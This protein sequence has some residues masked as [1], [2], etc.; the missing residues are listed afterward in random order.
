M[1]DCETLD[2]R[3]PA[4]KSEP[5]I[6]RG[7]VPSPLERGLKGVV[8]FLLPPRC[9]SCREA[10]ATQG[11]LCAECFSGLSFITEPVCGGCGYPFAH[12]LPEGT[13]CGA[14]TRLRPAFDSA[15]AALV[16]NEASKRLVL[17]FKRAERTQGLGTL[18]RWLARAGHNALRGTDVIVPVPLHRKRLFA[19]RF[20]QA[21]LLAKAL[22]EG[23]GVA[24]DVL[25]LERARNTPSQG[26][27]GAVKRAQNVRGAFRVRGK[28]PY[29]GRSV[30]LVDDVLTTGATADACARALKKAGA[31]RVTALTLAR[32]VMPR[33]KFTGAL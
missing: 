3:G 16:Y 31:E 28:K 17:G 9:F 14:C 25:T 24:L 19:R 22:A 4:L 26:G 32:V 7:R 30:V 2:F 1:A 27:K 15:R 12:D 23:T 21:A 33:G 11:G 8:D 13:L 29:R 20:N 6:W 5:D 18:A 10:V